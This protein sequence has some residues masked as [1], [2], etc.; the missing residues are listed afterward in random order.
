MTNP[1]IYFSCCTGYCCYVYLPVCLS[2][3]VV[4]DDDDDDVFVLVILLW[5]KRYWIADFVQ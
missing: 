2:V 1:Q 3:V 4:D 5:W